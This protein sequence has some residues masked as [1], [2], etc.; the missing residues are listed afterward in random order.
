MTTNYTD[1]DIVDAYIELMGFEGEREDIESAGE[2]ACAFLVFCEYEFELE[3][4]IIEQLGDWV[5]FAGANEIVERYFDW[6]G[7]ARDVLIE[8]QWIKTARGVFV[9]QHI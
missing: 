5:D 3:N 1:T 9:F 8:A 6:D 7:W 4:T 2:A